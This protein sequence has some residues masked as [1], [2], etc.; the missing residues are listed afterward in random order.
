M[1]APKRVKNITDLIVCSLVSPVLLCS[2][3]SAAFAQTTTGAGVITSYNT[4]WSSDQVRVTTTAPF[5]NPSSCTTPDGYV[6]NP[7]DPGNHAHQAALLSAFLA[8]KT[9]QLVIQ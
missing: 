9:V 3:V 6:T 4:G 7:A 2:L 5:S 1:G 8:G